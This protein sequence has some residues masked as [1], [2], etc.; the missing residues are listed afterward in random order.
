M[1][2]PLFVPKVSLLGE[3]P[4]AWFEAES[5]GCSLSP[6]GIPGIVDWVHACVLHD[7]HYSAYSQVG[8]WAADYLLMRNMIR[9]GAPIRA[10]LWY[11]IGT[12]CGGW[13]AYCKFDED[14]YED[15][16]AEGLL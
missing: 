9:C 10:A 3:I 2:V 1:A 11:W 5:N 4:P 14:L 7:W 12:T 16:K 8:K 15:A 13:R 6:D